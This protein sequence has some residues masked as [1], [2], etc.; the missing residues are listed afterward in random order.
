[1]LSLISQLLLA[2]MSTGHP[3]VY[4]YERPKV[5]I[6]KR[7]TFRHLQV[8]V[9]ALAKFQAPS[10]PVPFTA[11]AFGI[12]LPKEGRPTE[13]LEANILG[14]GLT[15]DLDGDGQATGRLSLACEGSRLKL[16]A[17]L[18]N[19]LVPKNGERYVRYH[20]LPSKPGPTLLYF[21]CNEDSFL[22][23]GTPEQPVLLQEMPGPLLQ[24]SV[25]EQNVKLDQPSSLKLGSWSL[26]GEAV[27]PALQLIIRVYEPMGAEKI[28]W[29]LV[30]WLLFPISPGE[31]HQLSAQIEGEAQGL[32]AAMINVAPEPKSRWRGAFGIQKLP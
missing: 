21:P 3:P 2:G 13:I 16:G 9:K 23:F 20:D 19:P 5:E 14:T 28:S 32:V 11:E 12:H 24:V 6:S 30:H 31:A 22:G 4:P 1:M 29:S 7:G 26:D 18:L 17:Q 10:H 25:V 15:L 8:E 27:K